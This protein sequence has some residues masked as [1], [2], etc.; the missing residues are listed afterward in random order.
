M[1]D[2]SDDNQSRDLKDWDNPDM[3]NLTEWRTDV[4]GNKVQVQK[5]IDPKT[6]IKDDGY[7]HP[8]RFGGL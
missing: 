6:L 7:N 8:S 1:Q 4:F 5:K 3:F 2:A